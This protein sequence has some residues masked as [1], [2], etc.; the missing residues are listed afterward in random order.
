MNQPDKLL[1]WYTKQH[2]IETAPNKQGI[3]SFGGGTF[4]LPVTVN[5]YPSSMIDVVEIDLRSE[6]IAKS[7][8]NTKSPSNVT[9]HFADARSFI[10]GLFLKR[11]Y[12][13]V[14]EFDIYNDTV[15]RLVLMTKSTLKRSTDY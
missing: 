7:C 3:S 12:D 11:N 2:G 5:K 14:I 1:F 9:L 6:S 8:T 15:Y 4:T 13:V 10:N